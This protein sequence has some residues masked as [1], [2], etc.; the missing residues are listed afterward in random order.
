MKKWY[1]VVM[2]KNDN[3]WGTGAADLREAVKMARG[4]GAKGIVVVEDG[5]DPVAVDYINVATVSWKVYGADGHRQAQSFG[6]SV[7]WNFSK[8]RTVRLIEIE[9]YDTTGTHDYVVVRITRNTEADCLLE[10]DGQLSDGIFEN[11]RYGR[12]E[13]MSAF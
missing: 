1:A 6:E 3:D 4:M 9:R 8:C 7:T 5:P 12:V 13:R 11:A 2:D 10:M